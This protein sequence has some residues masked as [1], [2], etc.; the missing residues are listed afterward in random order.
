MSMLLPK[1]ERCD[2]VCD[3]VETIH[4]H[5]DGGG[6]F[7]SWDMLSGRWRTVRVCRDAS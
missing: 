7:V 5:I 2:V 6:S 1:G 4:Q 3:S